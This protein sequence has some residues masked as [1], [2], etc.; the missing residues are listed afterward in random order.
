[1]FEFG[2]ESPFPLTKDLKDTTVKLWERLSVVSDISQRR[3]NSVSKQFEVKSLRPSDAYMHQLTS[4]N[5][6]RFR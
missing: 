5:C 3:R 1:M 4:H 2:T 6:F